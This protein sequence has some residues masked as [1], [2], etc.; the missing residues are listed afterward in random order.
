M[1]KKRVK[2]SLLKD[3]RELKKTC[4]VGMEP[5]EYINS[6]VILHSQGLHDT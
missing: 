2:T 1:E 5:L 4:Q 3:A 6:P